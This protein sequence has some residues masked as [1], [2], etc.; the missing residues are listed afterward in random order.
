LVVVPE[1]LPDEHLAMLGE[2]TEV[3]YDPDLYGDRPR[4]L[5]ILGNAAAILIRNRTIVDSELLAAA[6]DLRVIGRLGVGLDNI[7]LDAVDRSDVRLFPAHGGNAVSVA[8]YVMG[9]MMVLQRGVFAMTDSM[10]A[11][12]WP[13]QGHAFGR[14]LYGK[15]L[16]LVGLGAIAREVAK[17]AVAFGMTIVAHD[18]YLPGDHDGWDLAESVDLA[19]LLA[20]SDVVSVH[21][22]LDDAT[23]DLIDANALSGMKPTAILINTSR[24]G[25]VDEEALIEALRSGRLGGAALDVFSTEPLGPNA[26]AA[27]AGVENLLLTPHLAGNTEESVDR[28]AMM[29]VET[30][31]RELGLT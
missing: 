7:D 1:F 18:P 9:A 12:E 17:R 15:S 20:R 13:R 23:K 24:G 10:K 14:E 19:D 30:V 25:T 6:T 29:T 21:V 11:G 26:A 22:P 31:L 27:F 5:A 4:L 2:R 28:V 8:E 3:I 16:G